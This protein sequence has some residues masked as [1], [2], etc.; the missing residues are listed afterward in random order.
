MTRPFTTTAASR[1]RVRELG[2]TMEEL[3]GTANVSE[4]TLRHFG[5]LS[6][7]P[8]TL[9]RLSAALGWPRDQLARLWNVSELTAVLI[10]TTNAEQTAGPD[11]GSA[12]ACGQMR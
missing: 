11:S 10:A 3:A 9:E 4:T 6:H 5:L 1:A 12:P 8:Q 7:D 2:I